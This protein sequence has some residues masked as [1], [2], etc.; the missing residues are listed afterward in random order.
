MGKTSIVRRIVDEPFNLKYQETAF[1]DTVNKRVI[2]NMDE[3][4]L[5]HIYD[6]AG[7]DRYNSLQG[8]YFHGASGFILVFDY[9]RRETFENVKSWIQTIRARSTLIDP[10]IVILGNKYENVGLGSS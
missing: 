1:F 7:L 10:T 9:S 3:V 6:T 4:V 8:S 2:V 5:L